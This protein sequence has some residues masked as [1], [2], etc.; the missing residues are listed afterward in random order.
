MYFG[1]KA[2][3]FGDQK[4]WRGD[5]ARGLGT[6][7][8]DVRSNRMTQQ[9]TKTEAKSPVS[10]IP[11][12][13]R[14]AGAI[15]RLVFVVCLSVLTLR[16]SLPQ[17]ETIWTA[18]DSPGDLVRLLLGVAVCVWIV[19]QLFKPPH[20]AQGYRTWLYFGIAAVP[21]A[22]LCVYVFW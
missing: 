13:M 20:D 18:Y 3:I 6:D 7:L 11:V 22:L 2:I 8:V 17:N 1:P 4:P 14:V 9:P 10:Q 19:V 12:G 21:F 5:A 15:L 16:V